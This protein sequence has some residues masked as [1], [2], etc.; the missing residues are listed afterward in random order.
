VIFVIFVVKIRLS[1]PN[2]TEIYDEYKPQ[3]SQ[4]TQSPHKRFFG[5]L[6]TV[7]TFAESFV[8]FVVKIRYLQSVQTGLLLDINQRR[9]STHIQCNHPRDL[10]GDHQDGSVDLGVPAPQ[11]GPMSNPI[12]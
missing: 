11:P 8:F 7:L 9:R 4:R 5:L 12:I 1:K 6:G 2:Q 10:A 3:S